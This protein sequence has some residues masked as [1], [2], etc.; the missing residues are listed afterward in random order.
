MTKHSLICNAPI[1]L[2]CKDTHTIWYPGEKVCTRTPFTNLQKKQNRINETV[3]KGKFKNIDV[4]LTPL[5][6]NSHSF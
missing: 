1:C 6:L 5:Y 3:K 4:A 2:D